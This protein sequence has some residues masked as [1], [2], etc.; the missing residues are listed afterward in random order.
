MHCMDAPHPSRVQHT[1]LHAH[2]RAVYRC[3]HLCLTRGAARSCGEEFY[4]CTP[5]PLTIYSLYPTQALCRTAVYTIP[6]CRVHNART[7][8]FAASARQQC[9]PASRRNGRQRGL[10]LQRRKGRVL[11]CWCGIG[12]YPGV[13]TSKLLSSK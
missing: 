8:Y 11:A 5:P 6:A 10:P 1:H 7:P 9:S 2:A 3:A 4:R 12:D 13:D